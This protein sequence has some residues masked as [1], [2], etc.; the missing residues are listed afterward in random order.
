MHAFK[1]VNEKGKVLYVK[2]HWITK[3]GIKSFTQKEAAETQ[4]KEFNHLT[5]D[6]YTAINEE[7]FPSWDLEVQILE[8]E[9]LDQFDFNPLDATKEWINIP[10]LKRQILGTMTLNKVPENFFLYTEQSAFSPNVLVPG[11]EPSE[12]RLLQGRLFSYSDTQRYRVGTNFQDVPV[13]RPLAPVN[14]HNQDGELNY[15]ETQSD[16]NYQPNSFDGN[17]DRA[18]G[19]YSDNP[20]YKMSGHKLDGETQ[21]EMIKKTLN[22]RPAGET[23]RSFTEEEQ[24]SLITN[25]TADLGQV[26]NDKVRLQ[27][28]AHFFAADPEYGERLAQALELEL[29]DI[30]EIAAKLQD[31]PALKTA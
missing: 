16:I 31:D 1:F 4:S 7:K 13:N 24:A 8:P 2:F 3:Q 23:Y 20:E 25:L 19:M 15:R 10:G 28:T 9:Q 29:S 30:K 22:F 14:N 5:R 18:S 12:D 11:V 27:M 26:K 6:L 17:P 21:Q